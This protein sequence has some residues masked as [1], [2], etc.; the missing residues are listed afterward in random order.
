MNLDICNSELLVSACISIG[1]LGIV[2]V[3]NL[4][5]WISA[6]YA[7]KRRS[8][9]YKEKYDLVNDS[10]EAVT[11]NTTAAQDLLEA[12][13]KKKMSDYRLDNVRIRAQLCS[14]DIQNEELR[15]KCDTLSSYRDTVDHI[16]AI[17]NSPSHYSECNMTDLKKV[18]QGLDIPTKNCRNVSTLF[19]AVD[20]T[21]RLR[22]IKDYILVNEEFKD[23]L[24]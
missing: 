1:F 19:S 3:G 23:D 18:A 6:Y 5:Y 22:K 21:H 7:T 8:D 10:F 17:V 12:E 15:V 14:R 2:A 16:K 9:F 11:D 13:Y 24:E 20:S 4:G